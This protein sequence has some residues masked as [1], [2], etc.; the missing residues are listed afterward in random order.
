[1]IPMQSRLVR[2]DLA[3]TVCFAAALGVA[4]PLRSERAGQFLIGVVSVVLFAVGIVAS[5]WAYASALERSRVD[6]VG[7]ANLYLLTGNTAPS[8]VKRSMTLALVVQVV[9]ALVGAIVGV[10]G[11]KGHEVNAL[12]FGVLVPMFG[13]GMNGAWAARYGSYGP[14]I[15]ATTPAAENG[16]N[17]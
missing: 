16:K 7:V 17:G 13:I 12:A 1:M 4:V 2:A 3:G 9:L 15:A 11:L 6:E 14:R 10:A 5:L 8:G